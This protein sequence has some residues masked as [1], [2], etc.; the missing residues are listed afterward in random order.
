MTPVKLPAFDAQPDAEA[1]PRAPSASST[2]VSLH[3]RR[4][5]LTCPLG[6][7]R[8]HFEL[9]RFGDTWGC[10]ECVR[11]AGRQFVGLAVAETAG[12]AGQ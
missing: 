6:A 1:M 10:P 5:R 12:R 7:H 9:Q 11:L 8:G 3:K 4:T 2:Q